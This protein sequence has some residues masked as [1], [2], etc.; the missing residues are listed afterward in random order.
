MSNYVNEL[1]LKDVPYDELAKRGSDYFQDGGSFKDSAAVFDSLKTPAPLLPATPAQARQDRV[2][3]IV[4]VY[5]RGF[6]EWKYMEDEVPT[7]GDEEKAAWVFFLLQMKAKVDNKPNREKKRILRATGTFPTPS[8]RSI[9]LRPEFPSQALLAMEASYSGAIPEAPFNKR[10]GKT[11]SAVGDVVASAKFYGSNLSWDVYDDPRYAAR[12]AFDAADAVGIPLAAP[13]ASE[14]FVKNNQN[15]SDFPWRYQELNRA[16][17]RI[18]E[19]LISR[20]L[21]GPIQADQAQ[22]EELPSLRESLSSLLMRKE[23][24]PGFVRVDDIS[25]VQSTNHTLTGFPPNSTV[26]WL[27]VDKGFPSAI[28]FATADE[29]G[30]V[31]VHTSTAGSIIGCAVDQG[32]KNSFGSST[33]SVKKIEFTDEAVWYV[34]VPL[35]DEGVALEVESSDDIVSIF[36]VD[37]TTIA[38]SF[39]HIARGTVYVAS[40]AQNWNPSSE[41]VVCDANATG[42]IESIDFINRRY[43]LWIN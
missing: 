11:S 33:V 26:T 30:E 32:V 25:S 1:L 20:Y 8:V 3:D 5:L 6:L 39:Q 27:R 31:T 23:P 35:V 4:L 18:R 43:K 28:S 22:P 41:V 29:F 19:A 21:G 36:A 38:I 9:C 37:N 40:T 14:Q 17:S 7:W 24:T 12:M 42:V 13:G 34:K 2:D 10:P 15:N 16:V